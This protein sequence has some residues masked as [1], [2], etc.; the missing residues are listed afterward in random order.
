[1][2]QSLVEFALILPIML[3]LTLGVVDATRVF[4]AE[5]ALANGVREAAIF[6][7]AGSNYDKWCT[8]PAFKAPTPPVSVPCPAGTTAFHEFNDPENVAYRIAAEVTGLD[9][10]LVVLEQPVCAP[11]ANCDDA[12]VDVT[13][14]A[15]YPFE[16]LTPILGDLWGSS[17]TLTAA[18]TARILR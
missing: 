8:D 14:T 18:T 5:I 3:V 2:G 6:A 7:A 11:V 15:H 16:P 9:A 17:L 4:T 10:A 1:M 13:I 12:S